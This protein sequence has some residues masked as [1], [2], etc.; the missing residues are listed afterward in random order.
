LL[1]QVDE[2]GCDRGLR[3]HVRVYLLMRCRDEPSGRGVLPGL[4]PLYRPWEHTAPLSRP[5]YR[6]KE[7]E[8]GKER[9]EE[10]EEEAAPASV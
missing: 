7:E 6:H 1:T 3:I 9:R 8:E 2:D 5:V 10:K 4:Q